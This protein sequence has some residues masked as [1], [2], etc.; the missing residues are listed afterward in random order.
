[1]FLGS[2]EGFGKIAGRNTSTSLKRL[3]KRPLNKVREMM[4]EKGQL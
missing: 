3:E 4:N 1:M 2:S